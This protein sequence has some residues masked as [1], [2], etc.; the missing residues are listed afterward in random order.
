MQKFTIYT[1]VDITET[2]VYRNSTNLLPEARK[3]QQ[4]FDTFMQIL[5]LRANIYYDK[6][7][8][9]SEDT[10]VS[11]LGFGTEMSK[12]LHT[13]WKFDFSVEYDGAFAE[14][15]D[16]TAGLVND[17]DLIPIITALDESARINNNVFLT[18][19]KKY[20][21]IVFKVQS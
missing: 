11:E 3:Q 15:D 13:L 9:K 18:T 5:G 8:I 10:D 4:N 14:G 6:P 16:Q 1:V 21:N 19:D 7:P 17:F 12:N 2:K 20:K